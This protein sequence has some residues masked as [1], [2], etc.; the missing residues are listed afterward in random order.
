M[1]TPPVPKRNANDHAR[2]GFA[3]VLAAVGIVLFSFGTKLFSTMVTKTFSSAGYAVVPL[4]MFITAIFLIP[5]MSAV[6]G[7]WTSA[8]PE[9]RV[10]IAE[11]DAR[12]E[13]KVRLAAA[14][15]ERAARA[16]A[17]PRSDD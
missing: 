7:F 4:G 11:R 14:A 9:D 12:D 16:A 6:H 17:E 15:R 2:R 8:D 3:L 1:P 10:R 5:L 13:A